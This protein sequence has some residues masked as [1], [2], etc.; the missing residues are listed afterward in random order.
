MGSA[1][2]VGTNRRPAAGSPPRNRRP[3][4]RSRW[5]RPVARDRWRPGFDAG[6]CDKGFSISD[7]PAMIVKS[8]SKPK[9]A[10]HVRRSRNRP[11]PAP[12][13]PQRP[14]PRPEERRRRRRVSKDASGR[15]IGAA[16]RILPRD[17]RLCASLPQN[18]V[19]WLRRQTRRLWS[20]RRK[21]MAP[22]VLEDPQFAERNG[23]FRGCFSAANRRQNVSFR[24]QSVGKL[25]A[26]RLESAG[27]RQP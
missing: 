17:A 11:R 9:N 14:L 6:P 18:E 27:K 1:R 13:R 22:Q 15:T 12:S 21:E 20:D 10:P 3:G 7:I 23:V 5:K 2:R 16:C 24:R 8:S 4:R 26:K 19:G 25:S